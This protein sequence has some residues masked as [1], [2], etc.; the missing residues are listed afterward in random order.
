M[1]TMKDIIEEGHPTLRQAAAPVSFPLSEEDKQTAEEM[2][3][4]LKNSQ[5]DEIA[6]KYGLRAGVGLAAPQ[7]NVSKQ[8]FAVHL[9]V[10]DEDAEAEEVIL[11]EVMFNPR[12]VSHSVQKVALREGE[13]CLSVNREVPGYVPRPRRVRLRYQDMNGQEHEIRLS[14]YEA[15]VVQHELDHLKG[16]MF[17]DHINQMNPWQEDADTVLLG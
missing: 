13:G 10:Y 6:E 16:I 8:I 14:D 11:S 15:I 9:T 7:I 4:F 17:Y 12:I 3:Q 2:L 5:D 1:I